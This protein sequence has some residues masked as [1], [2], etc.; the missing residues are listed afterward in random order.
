[1]LAGR[2]HSLL[3]HRESALTDLRSGVEIVKECCDDPGDL[4]YFFV[5]ICGVALLDTHLAVRLLSFTQCLDT[6]PR[7]PIFYQSYFDRFFGKAR[8]KLN[9]ED[10]NSAWEA[11]SKMTTEQAID[12]TEKML[13]EL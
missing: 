7:D 1:M 13:E 4:S 9:E 10:F 2:L 5:Q 11:G 3:S 8:L 6:N 12:L